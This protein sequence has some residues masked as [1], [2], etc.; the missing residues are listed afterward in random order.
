MRVITLVSIL[1]E[2][3]HALPRLHFFR[4]EKFYTDPHHSTWT[5]SFVQENVSVA[6]N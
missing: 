3:L 5:P 4:A 6:L 1:R 2:I